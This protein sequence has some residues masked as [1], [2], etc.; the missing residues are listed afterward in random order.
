MYHFNIFLEFVEAQFS[1]FSKFTGKKK[2]RLINMF[3]L[4]YFVG[5]N[6]SISEKEKKDTNDF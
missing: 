5:E 6:A 2:K 3:L 4:F 1:Q